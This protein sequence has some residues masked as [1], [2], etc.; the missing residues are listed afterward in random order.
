MSILQTKGWREYELIDSGNGHRLE[1]FDKYRLVRPD[2]QAI[3][4]KQQ[5]EAWGDVD[6]VFEKRGQDRER[7]HIVTEVP[8]TS[9]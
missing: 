5:P 1:R 2:P 6:A 8:G 4:Q 3:W 9:G 7:W